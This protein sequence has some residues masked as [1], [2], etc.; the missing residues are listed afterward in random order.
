[1]VRLPIEALTRETAEALTMPFILTFKATKTHWIITWRL[2]ESENYNRFGMEDGH[3]WMA[4]LAP[5]RDELLRGDFR[6]LYIGW[7]TAVTM[8]MV[9]GDEM[10]PLSVPGLGSLTGAQQSLAEFLD[11]DQDLLG[12][13][14][15]GS[16]DLH[17]KGSSKKEMDEWIDRLPE[18]EVTTIL[19]QL[20][21]GKGQQ[22]ERTLKNQFTAW[23]RSLRGTGTEAPRRTV[24]EL[25][26]NSEVAKELRLEQRKRDRKRRE[27]KRRKERDSALKSLSKDFPKAWESVQQTVELGSG[28]AYD[29][30]CSFLI[31]IAEAYTLHAS[32]NRFENDLKKFMTDHMR[33]KALIQ[34]LVK[35]GIWKDK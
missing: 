21:Q 34:R 15:I 18:D 31:K 22:A 28:L 3:G 14:G 8:E 13:A 16:P 4:Q 27:I 33:R 17:E 20:L 24:G 26:K 6:S 35:A 25:L 2:E 10:E 29:D 7:L 23:Q 30:A 12:G 32:R 1:M 11:I 9:D 19:K 5:L